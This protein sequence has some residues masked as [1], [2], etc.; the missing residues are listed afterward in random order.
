MQKV[1][2]DDCHQHTFTG[3][4]I[5]TNDRCCHPQ[6]SKIDECKRGRRKHMMGF[7]GICA[8]NSAR[9]F[10][11]KRWTKGFVDV[12]PLFRISCPAPWFLA[13]TIQA[14]SALSDVKSR[15]SITGLLVDPPPCAFGKQRNPFKEG[16]VKR[17]TSGGKLAL[18]STFPKG[19]P[20]PLFGSQ[21]LMDVCS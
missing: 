12:W 21:H 3:G 14:V 5:R 17:S 13:E 2:Q 4:S 20:R 19:N 18:S 1:G 7:Q 15:P 6:N 8:Q 16:N 9:A 11:S 10:L